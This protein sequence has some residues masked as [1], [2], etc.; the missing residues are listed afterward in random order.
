M[1]FIPLQFLG[2][3]QWSFPTYSTEIQLAWIPLKRLPQDS[4]TVS[5]GKGVRYELTAALMSKTHTSREPVRQKW[6]RKQPICN[7]AVLHSSGDRG[8]IGCQCL[9]LHPLGCRWYVPLS[10]VGAQKRCNTQR[11][12]RGEI[13][14]L[15]GQHRTQATPVHL[16][17]HT[18]IQT[19]YLIVT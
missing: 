9:W 1:R 14:D 12:A 19:I 2:V 16:S 18:Q 17:L 4:R 7:R 3:V 15:I 13:P 6:K 10:I 11:P 5:A 8:D